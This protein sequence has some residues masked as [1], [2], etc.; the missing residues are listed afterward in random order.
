MSL[1]DKITPG[2]WHF[3]SEYH[4]GVQFAIHNKNGSLIATIA[5]RVKIVGI[6]DE[7]IEKGYKFSREEKSN[8]KAIAAVPEMLDIIERLVKAKIEDYPGG[9]LDNLQTDANK[10]LTQLNESIY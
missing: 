7:A 4:D 8:S 5:K 1:K 3:D 9:E 10:L 6:D 2:R